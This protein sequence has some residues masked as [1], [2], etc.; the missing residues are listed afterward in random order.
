MTRERHDGGVGVAEKIVLLWLGVGVIAFYGLRW[1]SARIAARPELRD[2]NLP[3]A[4]VR[5]PED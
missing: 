5:P 3:P 2:T 1:R 4:R